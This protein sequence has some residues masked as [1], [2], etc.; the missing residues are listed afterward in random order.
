MNLEFL[1]STE[2][3]SASGTVPSVWHRL[4]ELAPCALQRPR[5]GRVVWM[6]MQGTA[7]WRNL[8][9]NVSKTFL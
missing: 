4:A 1:V 5:T 8:T 3:E 6:E 9:G 7:V 2:C